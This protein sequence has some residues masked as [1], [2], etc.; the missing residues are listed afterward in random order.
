M[1]RIRHVCLPPARIWEGGTDLGVQ[2]GAHQGSRQP[3]QSVH[4][5]GKDMQHANLPL[6]RLA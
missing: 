3:T 1:D 5:A 2:D 4:S 6:Q